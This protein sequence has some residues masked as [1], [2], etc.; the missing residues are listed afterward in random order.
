MALQRLSERFAFSRRGRA[1][2]ARYSAIASSTQELPNSE[3]AW[4]VPPTPSTRAARGKRLRTSR[5]PENGVAA[6]RVSLSSRIGGTLAPST[7]T[8]APARPA[9]SRQ[10]AL[11]QALPQVSNGAVRCTRQLSVRQ[12]CQDAGHGAS[13]HCTPR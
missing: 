4:V 3:P 13:V 2:V 9:Q 12:R 6:S 10:G 1:P 8:G 11:Y 5:L 7:R